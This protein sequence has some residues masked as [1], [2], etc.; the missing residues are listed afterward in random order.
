MTEVAPPA[1]LPTTLLRLPLS[2]DPPPL[3][4]SDALPPPSEESIPAWCPIP[5]GLPHHSRY[6]DLV[7]CMQTY[8]TFVKEGFTYTPESQSLLA[9]TTDA[10]LLN[11]VYAQFDRYILL[12]SAATALG[13]FDD[14]TL[15]ALETDLS[16]HDVIHAGTLP[17]TIPYAANLKFWGEAPPDPDAW[18]ENAFWFEILGQ[19][20][21]NAGRSRDIVEV[22]S[23]HL[24]A[25]YSSDALADFLIRILCAT[26]LGV[27]PW[28]R[29]QLPVRAR[30]LVYT[31]FVV[32]RP[33][34]QMLCDF[35]QRTR[36]FMVLA[37]REY[38]FATVRDMPAPYDYLVEHYAWTDMEMVAFKCMDNVRYWITHWEGDTDT[39]LTDTGLWCAIEH[40]AFAANRAS[41]KM[42]YRAAG[43]PLYKRMLEEFAAMGRDKNPVKASPTLEQVFATRRYV[44]KFSA[45]PGQRLPTALVDVRAWGG[46]DDEATKRIQTAMMRFE[47]ETQL[48]APRH[49]LTWLAKHDKVQF[50]ALFALLMACD[51]RLAIGFTFLPWEWAQAQTRALQRHYGT[52]G[53]GL[54][55]DAGVFLYCPKCR[56]MRANPVVFPE[57]TNERL[58]QSSHYPDDVSLEI[59]GLESYPVCHARTVREHDQTI[60][61][62]VRNK[63]NAGF[64]VTDSG[65]PV[66]VCANT[67]LLRV[68]MIGI[69]IDTERGG[70]MA[71][72]V[73]CGVPV[74][75]TQ[76]AISNEGPC[77]GCHLPAPIP[78]DQQPV[79]CSL[80]PRTTK[81][82]RTREHRVLDTEQGYVYILACK[83]HRTSWV[84]KV[85][86]VVTLDA[87][88]DYLRRQAERTAANRKGAHRSKRATQANHDRDVVRGSGFQ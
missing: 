86:H 40:E 11:G 64:V 88:R 46:L 62:R 51:E 26:F 45:G 56:E 39:L 36:H 81:R 3:P 72:C 2:G 30:M 31:A 49:A 69:R 80:C 65:Q 60:K 35:V 21:P 74:K 20:L 28:S 27:Y 23:K 22:L 87:V 32:A 12:A 13:R 58:R 42:C 71:L 67:R 82:C 66:E 25:P 17:C 85:E 76:D 77:C 24:L 48:S 29:C 16:P 41:V 18:P 4:S 33:T 37:L 8:D 44:A 9:H 79:K 34:P 38:L 5:T 75:W 57:G 59:R 10:V 84:N 55:K 53:Q 19:A 54:S 50:D 43:K 63:M 15:E 7:E 52:E 14:A 61:H 73:H 78:F 6:D 83:R 70:G 47:Y 68:C 1:A